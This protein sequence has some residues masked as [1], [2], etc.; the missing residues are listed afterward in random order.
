MSHESFDDAPHE[1]LTEVDKPVSLAAGGLVLRETAGQLEIAI[2]HRPTYRDWTLPKGK[3]LEGERAEAA[4]VREVREET[5]YE[6]RLDGFVDVVWYETDTVHKVVLFWRMWTTPNP[7]GPL[8]ADVDERKWVSVDHARSMLTHPLERELVT[9]CA[10]RRETQSDMQSAIGGKTT[11]RGYLRARLEQHLTAPE[12]KRLAAALALA[13][14]RI[15]ERVACATGPQPTWAEA[16]LRLL[17]RAEQQQTTGDID[18][19]WKYLHEAERYAI[20]SF[21]DAEV[22]AAS[23]IL[24]QEALTKLEG[25]RRTTVAALLGP[26]PP[27]S[28]PNAAAAVPSGSHLA[29]IARQGN[30]SDD[31]AGLERRRVALTLATLLRDEHADNVYFKMRLLRR[32][33]ALLSGIL[34]L[35]LVAVF[36]V[37]GLTGGLHPVQPSV[38]LPAHVF[39]TGILFGGIGACLSGLISFA[40]ATPQQRVPERLANVTITAT[41]PLIGAAS[42]LAAV[43]LIDSGLLPLA[44]TSEAILLIAALAFGFSERLV[45][46]AL[47]KVSPK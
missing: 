21:S 19:G 43:L 39:F 29:P 13:R 41:R 15:G 37:L 34:L 31:H 45:V 12:R 47:E 6:V 26:L 22:S 8:A 32:Q 4:A 17:D 38:A 5:G 44:R 11:R 30:E 18:A 33:M 40:S 23:L 28:G 46:G 36:L 42:G 27:R 10:V 3:L 2:V 20:S 25:W 7:A 1:W 9:R 35:L 24:A 14:F 16:A